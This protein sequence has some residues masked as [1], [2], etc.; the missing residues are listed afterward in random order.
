MGFILPHDCSIDLATPY[1][2]LAALTLL[3]AATVALLIEV[4]ILWRREGRMADVYTFRNG[5]VI[6]FRTF[7][8]QQQA[9]D[10]AGLDR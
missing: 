9:L 1:W 4:V 5:L 8:E 3:I 10:W 2:L 7:G 6:E